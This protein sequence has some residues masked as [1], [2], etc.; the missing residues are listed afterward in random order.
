M[1]LYRIGWYR[2]L[3]VIAVLVCFA[4]CATQ[5]SKAPGKLPKINDELA[6]EIHN[7]LLYNEEKI[8]TIKAKA[9]VKI[10]SPMLRTPTRFNAILRFKQQSSMRLIAS[11]LTF[12]VFDMIYVGNQIWFNVPTEKRIYAGFFDKNTVVD[13]FGVSFKPYD[14]INIFNF[15]QLLKDKEYSFGMQKDL[16]VMHVMESKK[17]PNSLLANIYI[18]QHY[19]VRKYEIFDDN[20]GVMT[21]FKFDDY[22]KMDECNVPQIIEI[23]WPTKKSAFILTF[24]DISLNRKLSDDIFQFSMPHDFEVVPI[25]NWYD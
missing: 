8:K 1:I 5:I 16:W 3:L 14:V 13:G 12:T 19:N 7:A 22:V 25:G 6:K 17:N 24:K 21:L 18:D 2:L 20:G 15:N 9:S 11:K 23:E 4:G 10:K